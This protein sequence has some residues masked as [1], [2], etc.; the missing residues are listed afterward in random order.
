MEEKNRIIIPI[1]GNK[2]WGWPPRS[3]NWDGNELIDWVGGI[4]RYRLD[5]T[6]IPPK[7]SFSYPF[8][9]AQV[10]PNGEYVALVQRLGTKGIILKTANLLEKSTAVFTTQMIMSI[11]SLS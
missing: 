9:H 6:V 2:K 11:H 4:V 7:V 8:D 10:S 3:L 1:K 5:Q